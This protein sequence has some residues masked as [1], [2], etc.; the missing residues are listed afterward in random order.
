MPQLSVSSSEADWAKSGRLLF[1]KRLY[2]QAMFCFEKAGLEL[3]RDIAAAYQARKEARLLL[4]KSTSADRQTWRNS[5][6]KAAKDFLGCAILSKGKQQISCYLRAG[7]CFLQAEDWKSAAEAF[8][9][10]GEFDL[11]AKNFRRA[12]CFDEAVGV[13]KKHNDKIQ[14]SVADEIIGIARLEFL[15]KSQYEKAAG[16]FDDVEEQLDYMEDYGFDIARIHVLEH[17]KRFADAAEVALREH[18]LLECIRLLS[19]SNEEDLLRRALTHAIQ[20]LWITMPYGSIGSQLDN[21]AVLSLLDRISKLDLKILN[22]DERRQL[23]SFQAFH[24]KKTDRVV[25]LAKANALLSRSSEALLCF[26][27]CSRVLVSLKNATI[28]T[29]LSNSA[30]ALS[31]YN[32]LAALART[33]QTSSVDTQ[34]LL[35]FEPVQSGADTGALEDEPPA[36]SEFRL[37]SSSLMF[38]NVKTV[39]GD[40]EPTPFALGLTAVM[41]SESDISR[42][43]T[44]TIAS[45]LKSEVQAMHVV[46]NTVRY[47]QPCLDF[48]IFGNCKLSFCGRHELNSYK[49]ANDVRQI[50]FNERLRAHILQILII[51]LYQAEGISDDRNYKWGWIH[52]LYETLAPHFPPLGNVLCVEPTK[53]RELNRGSEIISGWCERNLHELRPGRLLPRWFVSDVLVSLELAYRV[54]RQS[55]IAYGPRLHSMRLVE[56]HPDL[57]VHIPGSPGRGRSI[58]HHFIDFYIGRSDDALKRVLFATHHVIFKRITIEANVLVHLFESIARDMIVQARRWQSG[59]PGVFNGLLLPQSWALDIVKHPP[60]AHQQGWSLDIFLESL[61]KALEYMRTYEPS[62]EGRPSASTLY[63]FLSAP[64]VLLRG[65]FI[66]RICRLL[67][68]VAINLGFNMAAKN[69]IRIAIARALTGPGVIHNTLCVNFA[70]TDSWSNLESALNRS[71]LNRGADQLVYTFHRS[72]NP[73]RPNPWVKRITYD[74]IRPELENLLSLTGRPDQHQ[75]AA[76]NPEAKPFVQGQF[77]PDSGDS[78][79]HLEQNTEAKEDDDTLDRDASVSHSAADTFAELIPAQI[80]YLAAVPKAQVHR[81]LTARDLAAGKRILFCYRKYSLRQRVTARFAVRTIW[82]CYSRY[83]LRN[84]VPHTATDDRI[85]KLHNEYKK[86]AEG[87]ECPL[88]L[89]RAFR[90]HEQILLGPMPHVVVYLHGLEQIVQKQ[91]ESNKKRLQKVQHEELERVQAKMTICSALS[92][93]FRKLNPKVLPGQSES[94]LHNIETLRAKVQEVDALRSAI[95]QGFGESAIPSDLERHYRLGVYVILAPSAD[96]NPPKP[97]KPD[98]NTSDL[99]DVF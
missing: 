50:H 72:S 46:A 28:S 51:H 29:F 43:A 74:E 6:T 60:Q 59:V 99:G 58:I 89:A 35:G 76:L 5:F 61:Y 2:P 93:A 63:G 77:K 34:R 69:A 41:L 25:S 64:S 78:N 53:I 81:T 20:G 19:A 37:F 73:P 70:R 40:V 97:P 82:S 7:E 56:G 44:K 9:E 10:A 57:L 49:L 38:G 75:G 18:N 55:F 39:I 1:N 15:R 23:E 3:E 95:M 4:A 11:A 31:Y 48:A 17:H 13:V 90:R 66:L 86:D 62:A 16:L 52:R 92:K 36:V 79:S 47:I 87:I 91:K 88:L 21:P 45:K 68:L 83:R 54:H 12:G 8:F 96:Q 22:D 30:L 98:L 80:D 32:G 65:V 84:R 26:A 94:A 85:R 33:F 27:H 42:L 71:P 14:K 67:I 24:A